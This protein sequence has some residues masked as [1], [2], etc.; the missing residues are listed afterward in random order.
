MSSGK[1][2]H[3]T[4][5]SR[6]EKSMQTAVFGI[7]QQVVVL[8]CSFIG[9]TIFIHTLGS[10][11]L[12][13]NGLFSNILTILSLAE[14]G[15][16]TAIN[17]CL[18]KPLAEN[19][20]KKIAAL[21]NY[22]RRIYSI[23]ALIVFLVGISL[24]PFLDYLVKSDSDIPHLKL[25]YCL[26]LMQTVVSYC[27]VYKMALFNANQQGYMVTKYGIFTYVLQFLLQSVFLVT[28]HNFSLYLISAIA[29]TLINNILISRKADKTYTYMNKS[30]QL[31]REE[32]RNIFTSVKSLFV[33]RIG[34]VLLNGTDN[35]LISMLSGLSSV[36]LYSNYLMIVGAVKGFVTIL[37]R[38]VQASI[39]NL[40]VSESRETQLK[41]FQV[42]DLVSFAMYGGCAICF[43]ALLN[44][45]I[46]V[47]IGQDYLFS[48]VIV[49]II[50]LNFYIPGTLEITTMFRDAIGLF[51]KTKY[52][53]LCTSILNLVFSIVLG[54]VFG[55]AGV[56]SGTI[57]SRLMT[58][59]AYEP[60][61]LFH[62][63]FNCSSKEYFVKQAFQIVFIFVNVACIK[64]LFS[65]MGVG[66]WWLL[67]KFATTGIWVLLAFWVV[68]HKTN[69]YRYIVDNVLRAPIN[70]IFNRIKKR[71][72]GI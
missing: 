10:E 2:G 35:I 72:D 61:V 66:F 4:S 11:Y 69:E 58:N 12:G 46:L 22:Y 62:T 5:K 42:M 16:G 65:M 31:S 23:I 29:C 44:E 27:F 47:W 45:F 7:V 56:L 64:A 51:N 8:L 14:L 36:G 49:A 71:D 17:Y 43:W 59:F 52:V 50:V 68:Y 37:F 53:Y 39:G 28:T 19:D 30:A 34:G 6:I 48:E 38:S 21:M 67:V 70:R 20:Q 60:Y 33:Y 57:I 24:T 55:L 32:K 15:F 13:I 63:H 18:Y 3:M 40:S 41:L 26:I 25:Y 1:K 54:K 9:R